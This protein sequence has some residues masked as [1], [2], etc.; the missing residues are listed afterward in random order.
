MSRPAPL[1]GGPG[2]PP[3]PSR[4]LTLVSA[5]GAR[6][7]AEVRGP[8]G[9][10]PVAPSHGWT[11]S[12]AFWAGAR[13][14]AGARV[15]PSPAGRVRTRITGRVLGS[16]APLAPVAPVAP[17]VCNVH[18]RPRAVRHARSAVIGALAL[19]HGVGEVR[20]PA[21]VLHGTS[22]RLAPPVHARAPGAAQ[23]RCAGLT[24]LPGIGRM[25][26]ME[27]PRA[28]TGRIRERA[29][30]CRTG[31]GHGPD[32]ERRRVPGQGGAQ[33]EEGA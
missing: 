16:R 13:R 15:A 27:A 19:D 4:T 17:R 32:H 23:P 10:P 31:A 20:V 6:P 2:A 28:V 29:V 1:A 12:T 26:P 21:A 24:E 22:D 18:A 25:M 7:P 14:V 11:R 5:D 9:A 30:A 8:D 33:T 3:L